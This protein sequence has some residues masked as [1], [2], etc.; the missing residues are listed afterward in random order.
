[1]SGGGTDVSGVW[2]ACGPPSAPR[3]QRSS[4]S[5]SVVD[6][7]GT[8][9]GSST[10]EGAAPVEFARRAPPTGPFVSQPRLAPEDLR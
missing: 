1:M 6:G 7:G 5:S 9:R 4:S 3:C 8:R 10:V 2:D